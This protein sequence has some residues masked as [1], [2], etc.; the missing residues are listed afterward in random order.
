MCIS[1]S[2]GFLEFVIT[3]SAVLSHNYFVGPCLDNPSS[4][5]M[6]EIY[7]EALAPE[8]AAIN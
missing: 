7:F 2:V 5:R 3:I 4:S 1:L 6:E 8:T